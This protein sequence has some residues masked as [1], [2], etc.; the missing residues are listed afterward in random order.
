M[1]YSSWLSEV[2]A[3]EQRALIYLVA[4]DFI[5]M[6]AWWFYRDKNN[7]VCFPRYV[8]RTSFSS[9]YGKH[10]VETETWKLFSTYNRTRSIYVISSIRFIQSEHMS[11]VIS[12]TA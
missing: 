12:L 8:F 1:I 3:G 11:E 4:F 9:T 5:I 7:K 6:T 2:N 10:T